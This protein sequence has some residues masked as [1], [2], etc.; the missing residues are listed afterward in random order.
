MIGNN[1]VIQTIPIITDEELKVLT[2]I[3]IAITRGKAPNIYKVKQNLYSAI[4][5]DFVDW[6]VEATKTKK[7][8]LIGATDMEEKWN[9]KTRLPLRIALVKQFKG[10]IQEAANEHLR[11]LKEIEFQVT[12]KKNGTKKTEIR[13]L[14][15]ASD[16]EFLWYLAKITKSKKEKITKGEDLSKGWTNSNRYSVRLSIIKRFHKSI[17]R[18]QKLIDKS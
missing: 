11:P 4:D 3:E 6:L 10:L 8:D 18:S 9:N 12:I 2:D 7:E 17:K 5:S 14:Y 16:D 13:N 1:N 15:T